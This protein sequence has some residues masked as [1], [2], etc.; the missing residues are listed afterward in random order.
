[1][2]KASVAEILNLPVSER[3]QLVFDIWESIA[4]VPESVSLTDAQKEE[5]EKRLEAYHE[6]P[7]AGS[8]WNAVKSRILTGS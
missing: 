5:L 4:A 6:D 2:R 1:M 3:I 7:T 8:P